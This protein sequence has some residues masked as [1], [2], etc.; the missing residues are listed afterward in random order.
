MGDDHGHT[1]VRQPT[2]IESSLAGQAT[3]RRRGLWLAYATI[4]WNVIEC[5]IAVAAGTAAGSIALIGFGLDSA[6]E[7]A[8]ASVIVWQFRAER[9]HGVDERRE[10]I[11]LR[12]IALSFFALAAYVTV[13]SAFD[14]F[15]AGEAGTSAVGIALA[16]ISLLVMPA[17]AVMKRRTGQALGSRTLIADAAETF[18]CTYLSAVLLVGLLLNATV[19][20]W[21]ADP[22]AA[23]VIAGL[24]LKEG[25]EA[26]R[27]EDCC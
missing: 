2:A 23:L 4:G 6:V 5:V 18:L 9:R 8:S 13:Q 11:A 19:G 14:L 16:A 15:G 27:G 10:Q 24:A 22:L 12:L 17:L 25:R 21:W 20:W 26:W 7:V 3:L 1:P